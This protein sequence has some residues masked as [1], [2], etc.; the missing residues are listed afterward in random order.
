MLWMNEWMEFIQIWK[1]FDIP[2]TNH[3]QSNKEKGYQD[4]N[5]LYIKYQIIVFLPSPCTHTHID[6]N[7]GKNPNRWIWKKEEKETESYSNESSWKK[8][9]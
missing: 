1:R 2:H 7:D 6:E 3:N 5:I 8:A 9:L 4:Y